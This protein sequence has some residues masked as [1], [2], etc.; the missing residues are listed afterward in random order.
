MQRALKLYFLRDECV[1]SITTVL[2]VF[3]LQ[4]C[5]EDRTL[6]CPFPKKSQAHKLQYRSS[7][8]PQ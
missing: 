6:H 3:H 2:A 4:I 1:T 7:H 8:T 5:S